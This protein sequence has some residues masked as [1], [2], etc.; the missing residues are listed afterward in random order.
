MKLF[1]ESRQ[2]QEADHSNCPMAW[3]EGW[4]THKIDHICI[5]QCHT[6][7]VIFDYVGKGDKPKPCRVLTR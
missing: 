3:A 1:R 7:E 4:K 2:C 5:C 6:R